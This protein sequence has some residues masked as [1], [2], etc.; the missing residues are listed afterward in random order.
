MKSGRTEAGARAARSHTGA[1]AGLDVAVDALFAQ[2][3]IV[4]TD[5]LAELFDTAL[6]LA[7]QP[8]PAG[9]RV[10]IL[11]NAGGPGI[12]ATDACEAR[13]LELAPLAAETQEALRAFLPP[14]ASVKNPVDMIAS[15]SAEAYE[16]ALRL[17]LAEPS[18][19]AVLVVFVPP[20][21]T[22]APQ[23]AQAIRRAAEGAR[24]PVLTCF[25]GI[26]GIGDA[27]PPLR[28][29]RLPSYPFPEDA[30]KALAHAVRYGAWRARPEG[31]PPR[32]EVD[33]KGARAVIEEA[34]AAGEEG[35][36]LRADEV[37]KVLGAYGLRVAR[38]AFART[39]EEAGQAAVDIGGRVAVKLA[40][41]TITH[42]SDVG[43]VRLGLRGPEETRRAFEAIADALERRGQRAEMA[44]V[45][46]QEMVVGGL[47][48]FAGVIQD[49]AFGPLVGFGIGGVHVEVWRDVVFRVHP[50][51]T[52]DAHD[53]LGQ[54]RGARLLDGLRGAPPADRAALADALLRLDRLVADH[55]EV[56]EVDINPLVA[57]APGNGVVVV[58][59]RIRV[60]RPGPQNAPSPP[61]RRA[62][63]SAETA[64]SEG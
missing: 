59:A 61:L 8:I 18:V 58:D 35:R 62:N 19:D 32:I 57:F 41:D 21:A 53:M 31:E 44:G 38:T 29:G 54:I 60:A 15:A 23:V 4:R 36:W 6:L 27:L 37:R 1:L 48:T 20:Q 55:P 40:S 56:R 46:V 45:V 28:E 3:G 9:R 25:M 14:E 7:N 34:L 2:S 50:L 17:L 49:P 5:T 30:A 26:H 39:A 11:T 10:A 33:A 42:K 47:E 13:G 51:T 22:M 52:A 16:H 12:M 64:V 43:G 63:F 24:K